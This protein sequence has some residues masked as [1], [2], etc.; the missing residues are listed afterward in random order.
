M[1][2][3]NLTPAKGSIGK[4]KKRL[5]RGQGSTDGKTGGRGHKGAQSRSG[6]SQ[7]L[8]FEGGQMPLQRRMPKVG[9][10]NFSRVEYTP[11]NLGKIQH[12]IDNSG[13]KEVSVES[14]RANHLLGKSELVK[15]LA[16][17]ELTTKINVSV[18]AISEAAKAKIEGLGGSVTIVKK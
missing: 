17:G 12:L 10:K 5:G 15:V 11:L 2:L 3:H 4:A 8:G 9:F 6:Y 7:K 13:L 1:E 14:L 16:S 18:H